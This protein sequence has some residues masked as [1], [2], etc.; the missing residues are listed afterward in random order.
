MRNVDSISSPQAAVSFIQSIIPPDADAD[1]VI[2]TLSAKLSP[3]TGDRVVWR[4]WHENI[5]EVGSSADFAVT[6]LIVSTSQ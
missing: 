6:N 3:S 1:L 2:N 5:V 4:V